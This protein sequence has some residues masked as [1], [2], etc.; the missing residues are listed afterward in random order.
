M[1]FSGLEIWHG[2]ESERDVEDKF[3]APGEL[4]GRKVLW[5][6]YETG[7]YSG[8]AFILF[9]GMDGE[10]YEV[11]GGHCSCYDLEGQWYPEKTTV[12]ALLMRKSLPKTLREALEAGYG[13]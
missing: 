1:D 4:Q 13:A 9:Q 6:E 5:A 3:G 2:F 11:N 12:A 7:N 10:L 8:E